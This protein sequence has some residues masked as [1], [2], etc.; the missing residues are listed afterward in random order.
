MKPMTLKQQVTTRCLSLGEC[1]NM[2]LCQYSAL[3]FFL[4]NEE[5]Q[6]AAELLEKME[7]PILKFFLCFYHHILDK[8]NKVNENF[9]SEQSRIPNDRHRMCGLINE[10]LKMY[11]KD[12]YVDQEFDDIANFDLKISSQFKPLSDMLLGENALEHLKKC[13]KEKLITEKEI[14][15]CLV[16]SRLILIEACSSLKYKF[17]YEQDWLSHLK[18]FNPDNT[19]SEDFHR[20]NPSIIDIF[21]SF[22]FL[23][24]YTANEKAQADNEWKKLST[25][26][27]EEDMREEGLRSDKFWIKMKKCTQDNAPS[28]AILPKIAIEILLV[29]PSNASIERRWSLMNNFQDKK[30]C[31]LSRET[32]GAQMKAYSYIDGK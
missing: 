23:K 20:N 32:L 5:T 11:L 19:L 21:Q 27:F 26:V 22:P 12:D 7:D 4:K 29:V 16:N 1:I 2:I 13:R 31:R 8:F 15:D 18:F 28:F 9:Q 6:D 17:D 14:V 30:R 24:K 10:I 3:S 25:Y